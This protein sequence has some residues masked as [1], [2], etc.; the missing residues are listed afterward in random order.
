VR[1][2]S[3]HLNQIWAA[4]VKTNMKLLAEMTVLVASQVNLGIFNQV[5]LLKNGV[6]E[7]S[8]LPKCVTMPV[9]VQAATPL[10]ELTVLND[11]LQILSVKKED[12]AAALK[13]F[14]IAKKIVN[15]LPHTPF[16]GVGL[17]FAWFYEAKDSQDQSS[18][19]RSLF[20]PKDGF[21]S[22][23]FPSEN[24]CFGCYASHDFNG[25]RMK[26]TINPVTMEDEGAKSKGFQISFN[27]HADVLA[28]E[29]VHSAL[30][31]WGEARR[32]ASA[33]AHDFERRANSCLPR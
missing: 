7:E 24:D 27:F 12:E 28:V 4:T 1:R 10:I 21:I 18:I 32:F 29:G 30:E 11:R 13:V 22:S 31:N 20:I 23:H 33:F 26:V 2:V 5:W 16:T 14:E 3:Y 25:M 17:N 19:G 6:I 15:L 9:F 8:D